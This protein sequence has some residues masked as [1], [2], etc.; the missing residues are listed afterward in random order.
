[1]FNTWFIL[2]ETQGKQACILE[3]VHGASPETQ[4][5]QQF[6]LE[7]GEMVYKPHPQVLINPGKPL[8]SLGFGGN[9]RVAIFVVL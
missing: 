1:M 3:V 4:V 8:V 5:T 9:G 2:T 7:V 6:I